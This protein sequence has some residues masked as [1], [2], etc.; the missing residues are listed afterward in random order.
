MFTRHDYQKTDREAEIMKMLVFFIVPRGAISTLTADGWFFS[1]NSSLASGVVDKVVG[2]FD[3]PLVEEY[4]GIKKF[5]NEQT[6]INVTYEAGAVS[7]I[8]VRTVPNDGALQRV[9]DLLAD[10]AIEIVEP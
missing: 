6:Q 4:L 7:E 8:S 5:K 10:E 2:Y 1:S 3:V 9:R